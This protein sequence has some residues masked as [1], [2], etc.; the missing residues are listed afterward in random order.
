MQLRL[1]QIY[2]R[3]L[4]ERQRQLWF[5]TEAQVEAARGAQCYPNRVVHRSE[6]T[7]RAIDD[8]QHLGGRER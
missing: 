7:R 2:F 6:V 5:Q 4:T 3:V 1:D 8:P